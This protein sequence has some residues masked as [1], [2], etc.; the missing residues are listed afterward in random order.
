MAESTRR[1]NLRNTKKKPQGVLLKQWE[2]EYSKLISNEKRRIPLET[3]KTAIGSAFEDGMFEQWRITLKC[4]LS[5]QR[6]RVPARYVDCTHIECFDLETFLQMKMQKNFLVCPI[7]QKEVEKPLANLRIDKYIETVL[8]TMPD[9]IQVELMPDGSF[10]EVHEE[11]VIALNVIEDEEPFVQDHFSQILNKSKIKQEALEDDDEYITLSDGEDESMEEI[12][13]MKPISLMPLNMD[14][15][16]K[17]ASTRADSFWRGSRNTNQNCS[18]DS[19][20]IIQSNVMTEPEDVDTS[21]VEILGIVEMRKRKAPSKSAEHTSQI[22]GGIAQLNVKAEGESSNLQQMKQAKTNLVPT[23]ITGFN[24]RKEVQAATSTSTVAN[25]TNK[26]ATGLLQQTKLKEKRSALQEELRQLHRTR[27]RWLDVVMKRQQLNSLEHR[28]KFTRV[29][30]REQEDQV[31]RR[32]DI[33]LEAAIAEI[34]VIQNKIRNCEAVMKERSSEIDKLKKQYDQ[35]ADEIYAEFCKNVGIK[36][37]REY[38]EREMKILEDYIKKMNEYSRELDRLTYELEFLES[39]DKKANVRKIGEKMKALEKEKLQCEEK[40]KEI[41]HIKAKYQKVEKALE[42]AQMVADEFDT[43]INETKVK[44]SAIEKKKNALHTEIEQESQNPELNLNPQQIAE[45]RRLK[46]QFEKRTLEQSQKLDNKRQ[47]QET[48]RN[49]LEYENRRLTVQKDKIMQKEAE[50]EREKRTIKNLKDTERQQLEM[51][52]NG[53]AD[54]I[55]LEKE[56]CDSKQRLDEV[57]K[58]L[59]DTTKQISD[60]QGERA[61]IESNSVV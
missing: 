52:K 56:V 47:E 36:H 15:K 37:I 44:M 59:R 35:I 30:Y 50:I 23:Q 11:L 28:T 5:Q 22:S 41:E 54:L 43:K 49:A 3:V 33:E 26:S 6:I 32:L 17:I 13:E 29:Q 42:D 27:R 4:P 12:V 60:A 45:Y 16:P 40:R 1:Y 10:T 34:E 18:T 38:E 9:A 48:D 55:Q 24:S 19:A 7:C 58:Q 53:K 57:S 20:T 25:L 46:S 51:L 14:I 21:E 31:L 2:V 39:E 8:S 61:E